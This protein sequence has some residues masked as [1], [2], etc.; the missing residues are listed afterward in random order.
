MAQEVART[1]AQI[2][3]RD[4]QRLITKPTGG[5]GMTP[6]VIMA[7]DLLEEIADRLRA[8]ET[9]LAEDRASGRVK[10]YAFSAVGR[11]QVMVADAIHRWLSIS[12]VND[13]PDDVFIASLEATEDLPVRMK[14]NEKL[15]IDFK[16]GVAGLVYVSCAD[17]ESASGRIFAKL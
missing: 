14:K 5:I 11:H 9:T 4:G 16:R 13:G 3:L 12:I 2:I 15:D 7:L 10:Q 6:V 1:D 17:G 8:I